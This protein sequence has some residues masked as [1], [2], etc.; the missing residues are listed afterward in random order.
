MK[1]LLGE[2]QESMYVC[3]KQS[4]RKVLPIRIVPHLGKVTK[5]FLWFEPLL[6]KEILKY[7]YLE[8]YLRRHCCKSFRRDLSRENFH[9]KQWILGIT[10]VT[11]TTPDTLLVLHICVFKLLEYALTQK[12]RKQTAVW[13]AHT[14]YFKVH[15]SNSGDK[16]SI[17]KLVCK[18]SH[19][20]LPVF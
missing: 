9:F 14:S 10:K 20:N 3:T 5:L 12:S 15:C 7:I 18:I 6:L 4:Q 16:L 19:W 11:N 1:S 2:S 13:R 8:P 17:N